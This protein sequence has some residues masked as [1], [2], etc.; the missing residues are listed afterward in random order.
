[1]IGC[2]AFKKLYLNDSS[3]E[4]IYVELMDGGKRDN[5]IFV[6]GYLLY[7]L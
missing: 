7:G 1:V 4:Q 5:F 6:N 2:N 3:F